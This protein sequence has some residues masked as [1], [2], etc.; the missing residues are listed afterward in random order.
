[1]DVSTDTLSSSGDAADSVQSY[2]TTFTDLPHASTVTE[3]G[4]S[5]EVPPP[6]SCV[7]P[8]NSN[9]ITDTELEQKITDIKKQLTV[10]KSSLSSTLR[11]KT[12]APDERISS[13]S[14]GAVGICVIVA[15]SMSVVAADVGYL[16]RFVKSLR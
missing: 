5:T 1:M 13:V 6:C 10:N 15:L 7:C 4:H 14:M 16:I 12:S 11:K 3:S 9:N 2:S 8:T